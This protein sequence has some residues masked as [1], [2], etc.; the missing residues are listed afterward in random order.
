MKITFATRTN[1]YVAKKLVKYVPGLWEKMLANRVVCQITIRGNAHF[2][3]VESAVFDEIQ[4]FCEDGVAR[5]T[6]VTDA[7][8]VDDDDNILSED[9]TSTEVFATVVDT[10]VYFEATQDADRFMRNFVVLHKISN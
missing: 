3:N 4:K 7:T 6:T 8:W 5:Y 2:S 1:K 9:D 10:V